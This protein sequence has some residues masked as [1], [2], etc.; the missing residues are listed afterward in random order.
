MN[1]IDFILTVVSL[2]IT[3]KVLKISDNK[4][5]IDYEQIEES[6]KNLIICSKENIAGQIYIWNKT[7]NDFITQGKTMDDIVK[8]FEKK[9]PNTKVII[10]EHSDEETRTQIN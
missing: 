3:F 10:T 2:Y 1:I 5:E 7:T 4:S 6:P 8:F 9:Y